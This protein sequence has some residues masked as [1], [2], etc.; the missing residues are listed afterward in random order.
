MAVSV[1][2]ANCL[3]FSQALS[4]IGFWDLQLFSCLVYD[5]S[6]LLVTIFSK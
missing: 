3:A 5:S 2:K 4:V 1:L 6:K